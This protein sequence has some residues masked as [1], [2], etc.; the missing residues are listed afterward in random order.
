MVLLVVLCVSLSN[1]CSKVYKTE[2]R[3]TTFKVL[4]NQSVPAY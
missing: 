3:N 1:N 2:N 4:Q